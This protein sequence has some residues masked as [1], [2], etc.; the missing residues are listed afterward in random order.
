MAPPH[1]L[2]ALMTLSALS[3]CSG[4]ATLSAFP[5]QFL[6]H[7][8]EEVDACAPDA[9]HGGSTILPTSV[10]DGEFS[11]TVQSVVR[12]PDESIDVVELWDAPEMPSAPMTLNYALSED[13]K[14]MTVR[15]ADGPDA[16]MN[17][18]QRLVRCGGGNE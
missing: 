12:K 7:W 14:S 17:K 4:K 8:A 3:G 13:G 1:A 9:V 10:A 18:P 15:Q 2:F 11:G 6:G 5:E 16:A